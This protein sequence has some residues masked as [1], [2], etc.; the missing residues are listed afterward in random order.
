MR[1]LIYLLPG[2]LL[3]MASCRSGLASSPDVRR[4][5]A[6]RRTQSLRCVLAAV[7]FGM[8]MTSL[9]SWLAVIDVDKTR[10]FALSGRLILGA[11]IAGLSLGLTGCTPGVCLAQLG[12][13][14]FV[15]ALCGVLGTVTGAAVFRMLGGV[16]DALTGWLP[17]RAVTLFRT[18]LDKP[19]LVQGGF[20][21]VACIGGAFLLLSLLL[22]RRREAE[23]I[24]DAPPAMSPPPP[25][26]DL[27]AETFVAALPDEEPIIVDTAADED[28]SDDDMPEEPPEDDEDALRELALLDGTVSDDQP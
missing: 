21:G 20:G 15:E 4:M 10:V 16:P 13:G 5:L 2:L 27:P 9:L 11:L 3:G 8:L 1:L 14:R 18:T 28:A 26:D 22:P 19:W 7:G 12:G 6:G 17:G 23:A 24:P 25:P